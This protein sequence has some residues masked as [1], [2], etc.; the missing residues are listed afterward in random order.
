MTDFPCRTERRDPSH[1]R[2]TT[3]DVLILNLIA[4]AQPVT[5]PQIRRFLDTST[6]MTRR[7]MRVLR[8]LGLVQVHVNALHEVSR[9]TLTPKAKGVLA[10]A[11]GRDPGDFR[12]VRGLGKV[13][14]A[15]HAGVVDAYVDLTVA[16]A[17]SRTFALA[18]W[19]FEREIRK[20]LG[21]TAKTL[22]PDATA[23]IELRS[24]RKM[25]LAFEVDLAN[26]PLS[27]FVRTKIETYVDLHEAGHPLRQ[28]EQWAVCCVVPSQRRMNRLAL[29]AWEAGIPEGLWYFVVAD[30]LTPRNVLQAVW[31]T[32][33]MADERARL[34]D[35]SPLQ[36]VIAEGDL[37][38]HG[39]DGET[40]RYCRVFAA[41]GMGSLAHG[42]VP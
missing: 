41:D 37:G 1:A 8:D 17:R 33:R 10:R 34:V 38:N 32:P 23:V 16:C 18:E 3:R 39:L 31:K 36:T 2:A 25:A 35:E 42:D 11:L 22:V 4:Q 6:A 30:S 12:A 20:L 19:M 26:E 28:C 15:H 27:Y 21:A 13:N 40:P 14:L 7:R 29:A 9:Y 5:T 24:G